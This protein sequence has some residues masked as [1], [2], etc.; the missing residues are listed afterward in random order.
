MSNEEWKIRGEQE[1]D[2]ERD[3][4]EEI[5]DGICRLAL[6]LHRLYQHQKEKNARESSTHGTKNR[7]GVMNE[8]FSEVNITIGMEGGSKI[9]LIEIKKEA[10]EKG[11]T[12]K[13]EDKQG[14]LS[15]GSKK[16]DWVRTL[17]SGTSP[18]MINKKHDISHRARLLRNDPTVYPNLK[19]KDRRNSA[20]ASRQYKRNVCV[21]NSK[22]LELGWRS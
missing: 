7:A 5:K 15:L 22:L 13:S 17:R 4:E 2:T 21:E 14:E 9:E 10:R 16:F 8:G 1:K 19:L 18:V 20:S 3:L 12:A 6:R 11:R